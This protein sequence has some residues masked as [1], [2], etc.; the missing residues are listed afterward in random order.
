MLIFHLA[1]TKCG[2]FPCCCY[3]SRHFTNNFHF[4]R[5]LIH[6][7]VCHLHNSK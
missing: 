7:V 6:K 1:D 5:K 4:K 2:N 3:F